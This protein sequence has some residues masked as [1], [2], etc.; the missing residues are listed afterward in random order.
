ME[1]GPTLKGGTMKKNVIIAFV[2]T[3]T[4]ALAQH[5]R[6][7]GSAMGHDGGA[8]VSHGPMSGS[9]THGSGSHSNPKQGASTDSGSRKK[10]DQKLDGN[11]KLSAKLQS[12]LPAGTDL[13]TA[14]AGFKNFGQFVAAVHVSNNLGIPFDQLRAKMTGDNA[15]SLGKAIKELKPDADANAEAKKAQQQAAED[16]KS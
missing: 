12:L 11:P 7:G 10:I 16:Q 4:L 2:L 13:K 8:G 1:E 5:G 9:S 14:A 3:S 6:G 15:E